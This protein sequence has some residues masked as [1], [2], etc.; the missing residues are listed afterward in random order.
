[1]QTSSETYRLKPDP[2]SS[3]SVVLRWLAQG[4]GRRLLDVGAADGL[5]SRHL[6]EC[7]WKVTAIERNPET[8]EAGRAHCELMVVADLDR[9]IPALEGAF[10]VIVYGDILEHLAAPLS[11]LRA[12][13]R[14]LAAGGEVLISIPNVAHLWIRLCLLVGRFEYLDRGI[15]DASHLR[16]FTDRSL[17]MLID[18]AGLTIV[19]R[20]VTP[21][22]LYQVLPRP[23]HG[24]TLRAAHA[25]NA[26]TARCLPRLLAYQFV[27][28]ARV[29][30][31]P[32]SR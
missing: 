24:A 23:W 25:L 10:D 7:G 29:K 12:L 9:E 2:S 31:S 19:R 1:M 5:L 28:L 13:N 32:P 20:T 4:R 11:V 27:V 22:P 17:G 8:A 26:W 30:E 15:L 6:T 21:A 14:F 16:F 3:H 18:Q